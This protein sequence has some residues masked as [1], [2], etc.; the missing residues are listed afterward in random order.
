MFDDFAGYRLFSVSLVLFLC[1]FFLFQFFASFFG[2]WALAD[3]ATAAIGISKLLKR[4]QANKDQTGSMLL[5]L[6]IEIVLVAPS[7]MTVH[8]LFHTVCNVVTL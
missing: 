2:R 7:K 4:C 1:F 8:Q 6:R 3:G 5:L